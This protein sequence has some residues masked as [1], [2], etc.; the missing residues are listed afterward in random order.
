MLRLRHPRNHVAYYRA[1][2]Q[3]TV[4]QGAARAVG[5]SDRVR[6]RK[7]G[8]RQFN[9]LRK[10]GL[11]PDH[12]ILEIGCGNL[13]AG[14]RLIDYLD[15]GGYY[16]IDISPEVL[17]AAQATLVREGV[18]DK[19]PHLTLVDNLRFEF[20]PDAAFD[21][22]HAHS[23]FSHTPPAV[24]EEAFRHVARILRPTG[25]FDFTFNRTDGRERNVLREDF[26]YRTQTLIDLADRCG[27]DAEF[28]DDWEEL[29]HRQSKI[30]V[31]PRP[32][33]LS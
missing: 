29:H 6:W 19:L 25:F 12:R 24:I 15:A 21:V 4:T 5:N 26:Y 1:V 18:T 14:W 3:D 16:G 13:R 30:R 7:A 27:L 22:I 8:A 9:Y 32:S 20:L 23:V 28:M 11:Q 2:M 31:R 10:H 17:L 33:P